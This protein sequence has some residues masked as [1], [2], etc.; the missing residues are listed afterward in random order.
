MARDEYDPQDARA[1]RSARHDQPTTDRL[2]RG[3]G[4]NDP[5]NP[6]W[7]SERAGGRS[8]TSRSMPFSRQEFALWLQYGGWRFLLAAV[9]I[10][11]VGAAL[12]ILSQPG[13]EPLPQP[14]EEPVAEAPLQATL[15]ALGTV[16]PAA[17]TVPPAPTAPPSL[18]GQQ[19]RVTGTEG[20][21][22]FLR[23]EPTTS[24]QPIKTLNEGTVVTIIGDERIAEDISWL[25][26]RDETGAEGW[27]A[28]QY[29]QPAQ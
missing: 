4:A 14:G 26:V 6:N 13:P 25:Q 28:S 17:A 23:A 8:R 22:L 2:S 15:P 18:V 16:T 24:N 27:V 12:Y 19:R 11:V 29:L 1:T 21:G 5:L 20:L 10:V 3:G 9:A 7:R